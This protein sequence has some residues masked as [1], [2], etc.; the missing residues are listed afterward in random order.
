MPRPF[1][2]LTPVDFAERLKSFRF[3]RRVTEVHM[4]HTWRPRKS[5]YRGVATIEGM[6][7][8]HT[9]VNGW[10]DIAQHVSIAPDGTVWTGRDWNRTPASASG[11]SAGAFMFEIIGDFDQGRERLEGAQRRAVID[12]IARVQLKLGLPVE[13]L[14]FHREF[15]DQKSCPGTGIRKADILAEVRRRRAELTGREPARPERLP[16]RLPELEPVSSGWVGTG[17]AVSAVALAGDGGAGSHG[18]RFARPFA[19]H[20]VDEGAGYRGYGEAED[21]GEPECGG[22]G[23][24]E[25]ARGGAGRGG[26]TPEQVAALRPHVVNLRQGRFS[27]DGAMQTSAGDVDAI[28]HEHLPRALEER[29]GEGDGRLRIV[30]YAHGGL[31]SEGAGLRGAHLLVEWWKRNGVYPVFFVWETGL[32]ESIVQL[33]SRRRELAATRGLSDVSDRILEEVARGAG[34]PRIWGGMKYSA[35]RSVGDDGGAR[36]VAERLVHFCAAHP[37][38]ELH[39]VGHSAGSIFHSYFVPAALRAGAPA[40]RTVSLLAPAIRVDA[41]LDRFRTLLGGS[42]VDAL[43]VFTM[44][45]ELELA[46]H[47][48]TV[49]RKSLLYLVHHALEPERRQPILGL[50]VSLRGDR[51]LQRIFGLAGSAAEGGEVVWS[52]TDGDAEGGRSASRSR[53]HGGFDNDRATM[54]SVLR[55][56]LPEGAGIVPFPEEATRSLDF[57]FAAGEAPLFEEAGEGGTGAWEEPQEAAPAREERAG[58]KR[59]LC[60]GIDAYPG[61]ARLG[62]CVADARLWAKRLRELGFGVEMIEDGGATQA[63][64][65]DALNRLVRTSRPGDT[66]V[67]QY[68]GHGTYF[69]DAGGD[70]EDRQDEALVPVDFRQGRFL[71][72]DEQ[73]SIFD[74]LPEGVSLTCFY[75][76]CHSGT[77]SRFAIRNLALAGGMED[78]RPR[79]LEPT[80]EMWDEYRRRRTATRGMRHRSLRDAESLRAV[81]FSACRDDEVALEVRGQGVFTG[82]AAGILPDAV[83]AGIS[84]ADFHQRVVAAFGPRPSQNPALD[85]A[86]QMRDRPLLRHTDEPGG[87]DGEPATV[88]MNVTQKAWA[89]LLESLNQMEPARLQALIAEAEQILQNGH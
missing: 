21:E 44:R 65:R 89:K 63:G 18:D 80:A 32:W 84:N 71:L 10:A 4:H 43:T 62:G 78:A 87:E 39:A 58:A 9:Q 31:V 70:E 27:T 50:D 51:E 22:P 56:I 49:Y 61:D 55:R 1:I 25:A 15:T 30:F 73:F 37:E 24:R 23:A 36:Y 40:F 74:Q 20:Q 2:E 41:F 42:G 34:G 75:D 48:G 54:E 67:F 53:T 69:R 35:E 79:F 68:A 83:A 82:H 7:R 66:L 45:K 19:D 60:V 16:E 52:T 81:V 76:C 33:L 3:T 11:H 85:C 64:I 13:S 59:A 72:D 57:D 8:H 14:R 26:L 46:D 47:C 88:S 77:M 12:V 17:R 5:D 86:T 38:V 29:R 28:F 6:W